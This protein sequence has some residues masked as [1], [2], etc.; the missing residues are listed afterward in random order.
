VPEEKETMYVV[1]GV[2]NYVPVVECVTKD[3]E[4]AISHAKD[5]IDW[6]NAK[7]EG[8]GEIYFNQ[9]EKGNMESAVLVQEVEL[10]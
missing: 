3:R 6:P 7:E 5:G 2:E 10:T 1:I 4:K 8:T 9:K